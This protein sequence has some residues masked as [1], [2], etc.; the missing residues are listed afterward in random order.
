[1]YLT[2]TMDI[3]L[4]LY[5]R[6]NFAYH[7]KS[8][9]TISFHS[10][11]HFNPKAKG[12]TVFQSIHRDNEKLGDAIGLAIAEGNKTTYRGV[13][14]RIGDN[15]ED[16]YGF[17]R[18]SIRNKLDNVFIIERG[19]HTNPSDLESLQSDIRMHESARRVAEV[20]IKRIKEDTLC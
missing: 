16:Y 5:Q 12:V 9:L 7:Q 18:Y 14:T 3:N 15:N 8:D 20:I 10:D 19:F 2:R 6:A 13:K 11:A 1:M 4:K 17:L